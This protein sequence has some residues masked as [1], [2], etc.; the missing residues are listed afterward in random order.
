MNKTITVTILLAAVLAGCAKQPQRRWQAIAVEQASFEQVWQASI[1]SLKDR[2]L[3]LDR[4][5]R[6]FGLIV[7]E[8]VIGQQAFEFWRKDAVSSDDLLLS[9]LHTI[10]R[11]VT[12]RVSSEGPMQF[13]VRVEAQAQRA[14]IP[15]DQLDNTAEAFELLRRHGVPA[16]PSRRDYT[17][18]QTEPVWVDLGREPALEQYILEDIARRLNPEI[19]SSTSPGTKR[20]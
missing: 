14:S 13:E 18:P 1:A 16:A 4:E 11:I 15:A 10:Q 2:G 5:D 20:L 19:L 9:S 8:P 12:V 17:R 6:R 7:S 3:V